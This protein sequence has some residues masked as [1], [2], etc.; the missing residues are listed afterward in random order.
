M[1]EA[2]DERWSQ[3]P[4]INIGLQPRQSA[5]IALRNETLVDQL[6]ANLSS[7]GSSGWPNIILSGGPDVVPPDN[8]F[9]DVTYRWLTSGKSKYCFTVDLTLVKPLLLGWINV[10]IN[11]WANV[12]LSSGP[13]L[14]QRWQDFALAQHWPN[15]LDLYGIQ[16]RETV[17]FFKVWW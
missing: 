8:F 6:W 16:V 1:K 5:S 7:F 4:F 15:N 11:G 14:P 9:N 10:A 13:T 2:Q 12:I 3:L 17:N